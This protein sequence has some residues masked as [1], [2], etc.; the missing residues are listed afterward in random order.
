[1]AWLSRAFCI[2]TRFAHGYQPHTFIYEAALR[3]KPSDAED[4]VEPNQER[5]CTAP[6]DS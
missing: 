3:T 5:W 6:L 4:S 2:R 1:M